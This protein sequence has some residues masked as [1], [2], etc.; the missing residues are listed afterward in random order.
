MTRVLSSLFVMLVALPTAASIVVPGADGSDGA[1]APGGSIEIDLGLATTAAWDTPGTGDGVYDPDQW[2][3]VFKY[4]SVHVPAGAT[5]TFK[6]HPGN[7]PVVWLVS[8]NVEIDGTV[9][10]NGRQAQN[11]FPGIPGPGGFSGGFS[12][13]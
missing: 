1:F 9:Q 5:V 11:G 12:V 2:A 6:N 3:V 7:P 4:S 13:P 8:G 10:V